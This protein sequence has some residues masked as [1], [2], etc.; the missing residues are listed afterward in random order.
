MRKYSLLYVCIVAAWA[1]TAAGAGDGMAGTSL[2]AKETVTLFD[3]RSLNSLSAKNPDDVRMIWDQI[4]AAATLQGI[5]NRTKPRLYLFYINCHGIDI[6]SYWWEKYRQTGKWLGHVSTDTV[7]S[8]PE[9]VTKF[10]DDIRGAVVYD[11]KVAATSNIASAIAGAENLIALRYDPSPNSLYSQ[12][13]TGGPRLPVIVRL[14]REDGSSLFTGAGNVPDTDIASS[15]S[16]K[17][18]AY[19]W[20][21]EKYLKKGTCNTAYAGYYIDQFWLTKP[22]AAPL[23]HHT[24]TNHDFFVSRKAFFFDLSPWADEKATDDSR[25]A[26]GA[27][28]KIMEEM[29]LLAYK[30]NGNGKTFTYIGGFPSWAYK[31]TKHAGGSHDDVP[32]EWEYSRIIGAY[33]AF[34]DGDAI[35][36]GAMANASFWQHYPLRKAYPQKW[37]SRE[38]LQKKGYLD[39]KGKLSLGNKQLIVFYVGDYDAAS[40]V[41]QRTPDIWDNSSRGKVPMMW[42]ISPVLAER[43][44]MALEYMRQT[45]T[46]NDYF[47]AADNGAGYLNPGDLQEPRASGLPDG[48]ADWANH[49]KPY[50]KR[51][52]LTVTGFIIDGYADGLNTKGLDAY[53]SFSPN[54]IVPQKIP[55]TMLYRDKM[56][57]LRADWDIN[58]GNPKTAAAQVLERVKA[59]QIPFHWFRNILKRPEWYVQVMDEVKRLDPDIVLVDAPTFFELYRCYLQENEDAAL[60]RIQLK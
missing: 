60:G 37:T 5:V 2:A 30:Q 6:D 21:I 16:S 46:A 7:R 9:L 45:A 47:A 49:C 44:P 27:D 33:N 54:G 17:I 20:F 4:H 14:L 31:Y 11:P 40:W 1:V 26:A 13:I 53:L 12:I 3:L 52:G 8:V 41:A 25:Q 15:G 32:T 28:R 36:Y 50:Y 23:N 18:D 55:P 59:R 48:T 56:P 10:K 29:L 35:G 34:M 22:T 38:E 57:V 39:G 24:L 51:W 58:D 43:A 19:R 42:S